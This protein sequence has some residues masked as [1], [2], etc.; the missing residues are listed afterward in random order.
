MRAL[1][2]DMFFLLVRLFG[3]NTLTGAL[4]GNRAYVI[5]YHSIGEVS[6]PACHEDLYPHLTIAPAT[7][8]RQLRYLTQHGHTFVR[9]EELAT[10]LATGVS[11]PTAVYF[12]DGFRNV[13]TAALPI[14]KGYSVPATV[15]VT[16]GVP[17]GDVTRMARFTEADVPPE[18]AAEIFLS[19]Q[20][21]EELAREGVVIGAHGATHAKLTECAPDKLA[22]ELAIPRERIKQMIG[23]SVDL[24]SYPHG[25]ASETV[26]RA[27]Q[28][29]GYR[30]AVTAHEGTNTSRDLATRPLLL[31]KVAP[32]PWD[33]FTVF[34]LKLASWEALQKLRSLW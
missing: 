30:Y 6:H 11:K 14:L 15:F 26:A 27:A 32:K 25:R 9:I 1:A 24:L 2:K 4:G 33:S 5:G 20:E 8:E 17:D 10:S 16:S 18:L 12:D 31:K 34:V 29:A 19:W 21:L 23:S 28:A 3:V 13:K 7:F 22:A